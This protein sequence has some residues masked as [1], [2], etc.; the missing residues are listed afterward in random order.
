MVVY[1]G[2]LPGIWR[3]GSL[4]IGGG[5]CGRRVDFGGGRLGWG[6][7]GRLSP[8]ADAWVV[9]WIGANHCGFNIRSGLA[10]RTQIGFPLFAEALEL[11]QGT[12]ESTFQAAFLAV[13]Q[14]QRAFAPGGGVGVCDLKVR[15]LDWIRQSGPVP[16]NPR[17]SH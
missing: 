14:G 17:T 13:E 8:L 6:S 15:R 1:L 2:G 5:G 12:V 10:N 16:S 11:V 3:A 9:G 7:F 4:H